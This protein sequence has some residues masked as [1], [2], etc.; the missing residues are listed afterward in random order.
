VA[1]AGGALFR[2][3]AW[4]E[5]AT[6]LAAEDGEVA[7]LPTAEEV[8]LT[9]SLLQN[10]RAAALLRQARPTTGTASEEAHARLREVLAERRFEG[11]EGSEGAERGEVL[12]REAA[13]AVGGA[14]HR[15]LETW[16]LAAPAGEEEARQRQRI[17]AYLESLLPDGTDL[18]P[19]AR[20]VGELLDRFRA[21]GLLDRFLSL[22]PA[23]IARELPVLLPPHEV[24]DDGEAA[25]GAAVGAI[26]GAIDLLYRDPDTGQLVVADY[27]TDQVTSADD[28]ARRAHAYAP[29]GALYARA[30][31]E[32]LELPLPPRFE[33]WLVHPGRVV[34]VA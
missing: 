11:A 24:G 13:M 14:F 3:P 32:A 4:R 20:R 21:G 33:L 29:Q 12:S 25:A 10:Q 18:E 15:L 27:K 34:V 6:G 30:V 19:A 9:A 7:S 31:A 17:P 23:V 22:G 26:V 5:A 28:V 8:G 1:D 16:D 2:F